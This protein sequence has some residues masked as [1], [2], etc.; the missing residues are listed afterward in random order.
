MS[1]ARTQYR[2]MADTLE[3]KVIMGNEHGYFIR[4]KVLVAASEAQMLDEHVEE[5]DL[6]ILGDREEMQ[7][8]AIQLGASCI[9]VTLGA[10]ISH[11]VKTEAQ[12]YSCVIIST[13]FD[14]YTTARL[15]NQSIPVKY[16][17]K[18]DNLVTFHLD[19]FTDNIQEVMGKLRHRDFP[20]LD[21]RNRY[22]GTISRRNMLNIKKK[23][24]ILVDH[25]EKSQA[26]DNIDQAEIV[27]IIDHHRLGTV[28]TMS[29]VFWKHFSLY[30]SGI[31]RWAV[32]LRSCIRCTGKESWRFPQK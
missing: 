18:K 5:D 2:S 14:T 13:P 1:I 31:S 26:V 29:P 15:I 25:N 19:D 4:G 16:L 30:F 11:R 23:K 27:E 32:P 12:K 8:C 3:G 24:L 17:M 6:L 20:I 21:K 10:E 9:V 7:L 22:I 28:E